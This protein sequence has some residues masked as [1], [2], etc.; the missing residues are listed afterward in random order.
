MD[1]ECGK[2]QCRCCDDD[3]GCYSVTG[4]YLQLSLETKRALNQLSVTEAYEQS[5]KIKANFS[6][7]LAKTLIRESDTRPIN[8]SALQSRTLQLIGMS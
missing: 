4:T 2:W 7:V 8:K 5:W 1:A 6:A 3:I